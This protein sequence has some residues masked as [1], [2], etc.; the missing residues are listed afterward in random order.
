MQKQIVYV[1][2]FSNN[3]SKCFSVD[4]HKQEDDL[5]HLHWYTTT[6]SQYCIWS[7]PSKCFFVWAQNTHQRCGDI[8]SRVA[9]ERTLETNVINSLILFL[10]YYINN[11]LQWKIC[12]SYIS[13]CPIFYHMCGDFFLSLRIPKTMNYTLIFFPSGKLMMF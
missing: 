1:I 11:K 10:V 5:L 6:F 12:N 3:L 8:L 2:G 13:Y 7:A 9:M 4:T